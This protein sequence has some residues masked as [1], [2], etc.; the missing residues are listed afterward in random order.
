MDFPANL[1]KRELSQPERPFVLA[2]DNY[3]PELM[4]MEINGKNELFESLLEGSN[5]YGRAEPAAFI[6]G[7]A[8]QSLQAAAETLS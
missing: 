6:P 2:T 7:S 4:L 1:C 3:R 8:V 5:H